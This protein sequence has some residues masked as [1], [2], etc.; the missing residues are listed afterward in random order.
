MRTT[1]D[2]A[3]TVY[4]TQAGTW[5][6][7]ARPMYKAPTTSTTSA[8]TATQAGRAAVRPGPGRAAGASDVARPHL[9][10]MMALSEIS[11]PQW[12]QFT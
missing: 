6:A 2:R 3:A 5:P 1:A 12:R 11:I 7:V 9:K 4:D 10:Q 8:A